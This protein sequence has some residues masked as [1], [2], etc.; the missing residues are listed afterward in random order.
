MHFAGILSHRP[1]KNQIISSNSSWSLFII[2][3]YDSSA[4]MHLT[5]SAQSTSG[6]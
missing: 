5:E 3:V 6:Q 2:C 1:K 4:V